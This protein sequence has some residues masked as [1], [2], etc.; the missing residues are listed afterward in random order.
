MAEKLH[1]MSEEAEQ[2]RASMPQP[3]MLDGLQA[4]PRWVTHMG[5][6]EGSLRYLGREVP[7]G[8][9]YGATGFAFALNIHRQL[10]PSAP[11]V[12]DGEQ[13]RP[14]LARNV[15]FSVETVLNESEQDFSQKQKLAWD[16]ARRSLD[17]GLPC[18]AYDI[19]FGDYFIVH[20]Y[21]GTGYYYRALGSNE[22]RG[23]IPWRALGTT[24]NVGIV[25]M[26]SLKLETPSDDATTVRDALRFALDFQKEAAS[27]PE[28]AA[29]ISGLRAYDMWIAALRDPESNPHGAS[30]NAQFWAECRRFA[31]EFLEAAKARVGNERLTPLFDEAISDYREVA[32][33]L[34]RAAE[35]F[36][37][38]GQREARLKDE[39]IRAEATRTLQA[40]RAA[41][42]KGLDAL[43]RLLNAMP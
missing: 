30:F 12:W 33:N 17:A 41:E 3:K 40:A 39:Q 7:P 36:P 35:L 11:Y 31:V 23:P 5:A 37:M 24:G 18:F 22:S 10:C 6:V 21:D 15:G 43:A 27:V 8:W 9:L 26:K 20:G 29:Y 13:I 14:E 34:S 19:E 25:L 42:E 1:R 2:A 32:G 4:E 28:D 16:L 38:D